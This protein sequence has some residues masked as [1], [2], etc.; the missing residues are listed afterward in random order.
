ME[1]GRN[2]VGFLAR[3]IHEL[4][5]RQMN[6][7]VQELGLTMSQSFVL[8]VLKGRSCADCKTNIRDLEAALQVTHPTV[9][10]LVKRLEEKGYIYEE[11]D[12]SDHRVRNVFLTDKANEVMEQMDLGRKRTEACAIEGLT[13]EEISIM[14]KGL[15]TVLS[16]LTEADKK[17]TIKEVP[18]D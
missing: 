4:T 10:G 18:Y 14:K 16:N 15:R 2:D 7:H 11:Q 1:D 8:L 13:P 6:A 17:I 3:H 9:I 12:V 5:K